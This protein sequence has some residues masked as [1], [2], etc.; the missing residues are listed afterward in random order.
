MQAMEARRAF[1][2][3][4]PWVLSPYAQLRHLAGTI[5]SRAQVHDDSVLMCGSCCG[6][7]SGLQRK[8]CLWK[9]ASSVMR[10]MTS[11]DKIPIKRSAT[12]L[13]FA[14]S[15]SVHSCTYTILYEWKF[16]SL[17]NILLMLL[18]DIPRARECLLSECLG[19]LMNYCLTASV[20]CDDRTVRTRLVVPFFMREHSF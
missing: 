3:R 8:F 13:W 14:M 16:R 18:S 20:F 17:C 5:W 12:V 7:S 4:F 9:R 11:S 6:F 1:P 2:E 10:I 19:P 15:R